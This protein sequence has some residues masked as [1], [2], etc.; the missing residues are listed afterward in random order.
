MQPICLVTTETARKFARHPD[1]GVQAMKRA[2]RNDFI[3]FQPPEHHLGTSQPPLDA[4]LLQFPIIEQIPKISTEA[5]TIDLGNQGFIADEGP[6]FLEVDG[7]SPEGVNRQILGGP[8]M[9]QEL[10]A[11]L[12][13]IHRGN[14]GDTGWTATYDCMPRSNRRRSAKQDD[15]QTN[16]ILYDCF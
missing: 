15:V 2:D 13:N 6:E 9:G 14:A 12:L 5:L 8:T 3:E 11:R 10:V 4:G 7:I 16:L 1:A